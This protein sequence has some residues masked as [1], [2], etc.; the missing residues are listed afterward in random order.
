MRRG[1]WREESPKRATC[2]MCGRQ[3]DVGRKHARTCGVK[4]RKRMSR[5]GGRGPFRPQETAPRPSPA[6]GSDSASSPR[7][8]ANRFDAMFNSRTANAA[9]ACEILGLASGYTKD[10]A[11]RAWRTILMREHPDRGGCGEKTRHAQAAWEYLC[12]LHR[13]S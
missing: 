10:V 4:C 13:W 9:L 12:D 5:N 2:E 6:P 8:Q 1:R 7:R 3:F 11:K